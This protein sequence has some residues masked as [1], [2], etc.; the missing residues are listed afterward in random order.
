MS[1]LD[2]ELASFVPRYIRDY[3]ASR[4]DPP[5]EF[6]GEPVEGA[7]MFADI[8]G[9]T[10]LSKLLADR[11]PEGAEQLN[12]MLN[13]F[14]G[15]L[16]GMIY[17]HGGDVVGFAGDAA[18]AI[19]TGEVADVRDTL[20]RVADVA[21]KLQER[22]DNFDVGEGIRLSM[23]IGVGWGDQ[24]RGFLGSPEG[25]W[26]PFV[27]GRIFEQIL[28]CTKHMESGTVVLSAAAA[29]EIAMDADITPCDENASRLVALRGSPVHAAPVAE[30]CGAPERDR[31]QAFIPSHVTA[32]LRA[33]LDEW[34]ADLRRI[35][36]VFITFPNL[37]LGTPEDLR[38]LNEAICEIQ[39]VLKRWAGYLVQLIQDDKGVV[40]VIAFGLAHSPH[41]DAADRA[42]AAALEVHE[43]LHELRLYSQ[44]G[45]TTGRVFSGVRGGVERREYSI[46]GNL[47]NLAARLMASS[48]ADMLCDADTAKALRR[49]ATMPLAPIQLKGYAEPLL[50]FRPTGERLEQRRQRAE[51]AG[52]REERR[53]I[54]EWLDG[55]A[56]GDP[57]QF[58]LEG[59]PGVGK[60]ILMSELQ[61]RA[62]DRGLRMLRA[63][64]SS[65]EQFTTYRAWRHLLSHL[66]SLNPN[67]QPEVRERR[68]RDA[69]AFDAAALE[70]AALLNGVLGLRF[71]ESEGT[72]QLSSRA[73]ADNLQSLVL[74]V[75][76]HA[77][78]GA[79]LLLVIEDGHWLDSAS[80][81][82]VGAVV[83]STNTV[84]VAMSLRPIQDSVPPE[85][86][87]LAAVPTTAR[88]CLTGLPDEDLRD[89]L[90]TGLHTREVSARLFDLVRE[91]SHGNPFYAKQLIEYLREVNLVTISAKG[92]DLTE[93]L[94]GKKIVPD[95]VRDLVTV[96][97]DRL[98]LPQQV[99]LKTASVVGF[100]FPTRALLAIAESPEQ[101][102]HLPEHLTRISHASLIHVC[103]K[104]AHL[105]NGS[106]VVPS[107]EPDAV[108]GEQSTAASPDTVLLDPSLVY[109]FDHATIQEVTY[110]QI[111][112]RNRRRVHRQ[113]ALWLE[114]EGQA[115]T[116]PRLLALHWGAAQ[117]PKKELLY[118]DQA[119][120]AA[121]KAYANQEA[122]NALELALVQHTKLY[123]DPSRSEVKRRAHWERI[124]G[125]ALYRTGNLGEAEDRLKQ[126]LKSMKRPL[127][128][129][130]PAVLASILRE[131]ARQALHR[132]APSLFTRHALVPIEEEKAGGAQEAALAVYR[133]GQLSYMR[134]EVMRGMNRALVVLNTSERSGK[135]RVLAQ[136]YSAVALA[137]GLLGRYGLSRV[138][139]HLAED[140]AR[141]VGHQ[142]TLSHL[143]MTLGITF[144]G[145]GEWERSGRW[146][147]ESIDLAKRVGDQT[148]L[149]EALTV[150]GVRC[151]LIADYDRAYDAFTETVE[152]AR[153]NNNDMQLAVGLCGQGECE[154]RWGRLD[155]AFQTLEQ[156]CRLLEPLNYTS[157]KVRA[158]GLLSLVCWR[159]GDTPGARRYQ[160]LAEDELRGKPLKTVSML[161]GFAS[162]ATVSL[163]QAEAT[164]GALAQAKAACQHL[165][166]FAKT[167]PIGWARHS[168]TLGCVHAAERHAG[169]ATKAWKRALRFA[170][171][172]GLP[173]ERG[174]ALYHLGASA[175]DRGLLEQACDVLDAIMAEH[176]SQLARE[177][178]EAIG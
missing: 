147:V 13:L 95:S 140:T 114:S 177:A 53:R 149:Y 128:T 25:G 89:L 101:A 116:K 119:G 3:L 132:A 136:S 162:L 85:Y 15:Q 137:L 4:S 166:E 57:A 96:R 97:V 94:G 164:A 110:D 176:E 106:A 7:L 109:Q 141:T 60:S 120:E 62:A 11:G 159:R 169:A 17:E 111:T 21:M 145:V 40:A 82:L 31:L 14:Y 118:L 19:W 125:E 56:R 135:S 154:L 138:Y 152:V 144:L 134:G 90:L 130:T 61:A 131:V 8:S 108:P 9:F 121:L 150:E 26:I 29:R 35:T 20:L 68:V 155:D 18:I 51:I 59:Q 178:L 75:V 175:G 55:V 133:L 44:I 173:L 127:A 16:V 27:G 54:D 112:S 80:W 71:E 52:R 165:K 104:V 146:L 107:V 139:A 122:V 156:T 12:Q 78:R 70:Q 105:G 28:D 37:E 73:R 81:R 88:V 115:A 63:E 79:P 23:K 163:A 39:G 67:E 153:K 84:S 50:T 77:S 36:V 160:K 126:S 10:K 69:L 158:Y 66:L 143:L 174:T 38:S 148:Y 167:L 171:K 87:L 102:G 168:L 6:H 47:V 100:T 161:E 5:T 64:C 123:P 113:V 1:D 98:P 22:L 45:V 76:E 30:L 157:E 124:L 170:E 142:P 72:A 58:L 43:R 92:C 83:K 42:V 49:H 129:S 93:G 91:R 99:T 34:L 86:T 24:F 46:T 117:N 2:A 65:I 32:G 172:Y 33:S 74:R 48:Q 151:A 103:D 41:E